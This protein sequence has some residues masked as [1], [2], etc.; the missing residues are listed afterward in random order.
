[1]QSLNSDVII[2]I[3]ISVHC[4]NLPFF[5]MNLPS[6]QLLPVLALPLTGGQ[7]AP[8]CGGCALANVSSR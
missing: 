1:M 4:L 3:E 6:K 8:T 5:L 7:A 2:I